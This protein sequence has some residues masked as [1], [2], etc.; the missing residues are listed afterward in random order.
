MSNPF[1]FSR[2]AVPTFVAPI[3]SKADICKI[4]FVNENT[5][6]WNN[7]PLSE[8]VNIEEKPITNISLFVN[9][10][11]FLNTYWQGEKCRIIY[12]H[13]GAAKFMCLI[14][15]LFTNI[16]FQLYE[17]TIAF[18][19]HLFFRKN[20]QLFNHYNYDVNTEKD[21]YLIS[22]VYLSD[23]IVKTIKPIKVLMAWT[24][25][26]DN[27]ISYDGLIY[28]LPY[29]TQLYLYSPSINIVRKWDNI[30]LRKI[31]TMALINR[32]KTKYINITGRQNLN[33]FFD[34]T[35]IYFVIEKYFIKTGKEPIYSSFVLFKGLIDA[36]TY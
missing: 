9:V 32:S 1:D 5:V 23:E 18:D 6:L 14:A 19:D 2:R 20:V 36:F 33:E 3:A 11:H 12:S 27:P 28:Q 31:F 22:D 34:D 30:K 24:L 8:I 10:L 35:Y 16:E 7:D 29:T 4:Q 17:D 15:D 21:I 26:E 25:T 13:C